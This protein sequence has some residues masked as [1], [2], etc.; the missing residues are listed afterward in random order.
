MPGDLGVNVRD[1]MDVVTIHHR[2]HTHIGQSREASWPTM[3]VSV[4][5][6]N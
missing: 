2:I 5:G 6:E 3:H 4:L 1:T